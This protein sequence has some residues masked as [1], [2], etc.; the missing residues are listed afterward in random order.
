MRFKLTIQYDGSGYHGWQKQPNEPMTVGRVIEDAAAIVCGTPTAVFASGRTD[1][2]V[3]A[4][5]QTAHF[6]SDKLLPPE[7]YVAAFNH[8]LPDSVRVLSCE[9]VPDS[10]DA[11]KSAKRKTYEYRMYTADPSNVHAVENPLRRTRELFVPCLDVGAMDG[12]ARLFEGTHDFK[13]FMSSGS[14][15]RTTV[16]TVYSARVTEE[17]DSLVFR[18]CGNGFLYNMVRIMAGALVR[19]GTGKTTPE[20]LTAALSGGD[21]RL[22]PDIAPPHALYLKNVEYPRE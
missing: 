13:A 11:R 1:E 4:L 8:W 7:R 6:D 3:H 21:R 9:S 5:G 18:V 20:T 2:G 15:A 14:S 19:V 16:R 12:A 10:F 22:V 17:G